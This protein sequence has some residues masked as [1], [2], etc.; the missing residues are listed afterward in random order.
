[1]AWWRNGSSHKEL[2]V[3]LAIRK[4]VAD[5]EAAIFDEEQEG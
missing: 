2:A 4:L 3:P 1:M 5:Q